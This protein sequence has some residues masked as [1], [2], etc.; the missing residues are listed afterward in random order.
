MKTKTK[1]LTILIALI[2]ISNSVYS[3]NLFVENFNYPVRDTLGG[4]GGWIG[5]PGNRYNVKVK[6]PGLTYAGYNGSGI[7]NSVFF[8]NI[9]DGEVCV[10]EFTTQ[11]SGKLYMSFLIRVDSLTANATYGYNICFDQSGGATNLNTRPY[12]KKLTSSTF[13]F[14]LAKSDDQPVYSA[15]ISSTNTTYLVVVKYTFVSGSNYDSAKMFVFSSGVPVAEPSSPTLFQ[16]G[17]TDLADIGEIVLTNSYAQAGLKGSTVKVDGIRIGT[18][19]S[20]TLINTV[21]MQLKLSAL[22]QGFYNNVSNKMIK[23]TAKVYLRYNSSPFPIADSSKSILDS[24]GKGIFAFSNITNGSP[25]YVVVRH[26]NSIETWSWSGREFH[27]D[28]LSFDFTTSEYQAY[29][30]NLIKKGT[31]YCVYNGDVNQDATIDVSDL[32]KIYN[33][34]FNFVSGYVS[35]DVTGNNFVDVTDLI[36][37]Y[38]NSINFVSI[39]RP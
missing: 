19:W 32:I 15:T 37:A 26:R 33:D 30:Q 29:G 2:S 13:N 11:T 20:N 39:I 28:T 3:Q 23:D 5:T 35:T 34:A 1:V 9:T 10:H 31:E 4:I 22:I 25:Y 6:S 24:N 12:V 7:G 38:N 8:T 27:A 14:G 17:G 36:T 21:N 16:V 18:N